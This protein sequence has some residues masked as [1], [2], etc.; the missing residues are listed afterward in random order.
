MEKQ[1]PE[2]LDAEIVEP[3]GRGQS[4]N[5]QARFGYQGGQSRFS[6]FW[7]STP[8]DT[9][10]CLAPAMTFALFLV[11]MGQFGLL[12]AIGFLVFHV[13]GSIM[14]SVH[15]ARQLMAGI[16][17]NPWAWRTGNWIISFLV[18]MWLAD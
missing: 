3:D 8:I 14:G 13:I 15:Q 10:G 11:C 5:S 6:G 12:A 7:T 18:T 2:V 9:G 16:P 4:Q 17:V 1:K